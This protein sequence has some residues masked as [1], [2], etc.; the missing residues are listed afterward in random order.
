MEVL[1]NFLLDLVKCE[2][3][4]VSNE[5]EDADIE[6]YPP[7]FSSSQNSSGQSL[8]EALDRA[9]RNEMKMMQDS[10][11]A[12]S[13]DKKRWPVHILEK[14][15]TS[16][17][18]QALSLL[19]NKRKRDVAVRLLGWNLSHLEYANATDAWKLSKKH[20]DEDDAGYLFS[21]VEVGGLHCS[22]TKGT[23]NLCQKLAH[24]LSLREH[25]TIQYNQQVQCVTQLSNNRVRIETN[26]GHIIDA[27]AVVVTLPLGV[28]KKGSVKF[29]PSLPEYKQSVIDRM[30]FGALNKVMLKFPEP[31]F[32][33]D[34]PHEYIG[35]ASSPRNR[36]YNFFIVHNRPVLVG[37]VSGDFAR[38]IETANPK[39]VMA[40]CMKIIRVAF[41]HHDVPDPVDIHIT[42]WCSD[43]YALG[44]YSYM[45]VNAEAFD[46]AALAQPV[47]RVFFAGE[48][49]NSK[50]PSSMHGAYLSGVREGKRICIQNNKIDSKAVADHFDE[51]DLSVRSNKDTVC[52]LCRQS[53][54]EDDLE[55]AFIGG[56]G[57]KRKVF[58]HY[59]CALFTPE[60]KQESVGWFNVLTAIR[61]GKRHKC[62]VCS[63]R[64]ATITCN[65]PKCNRTY[66]FRCAAEATLPND[67][68]R[69]AWDFRTNGKFYFC[70]YH[71]NTKTILEAHAKNTELIHDDKNP[72]FPSFTMTRARQLI[73]LDFV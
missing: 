22:L 37:I 69:K 49:T 39:D 13:G 43:P 21:G 34:Y 53:H 12:K 28:L 18:R 67:S 51:I 2:E 66:H 54:R 10:I 64:G 58:V 62:S 20:W 59:Y 70:P 26:Q 30:G 47:G 29:E 41:P 57:D 7:I 1:W 4:N 35:H 73:Q 31:F 55:G 68:N 6:K 44:S 16:Q 42:K 33:A 19:Q 23:M 15:N 5:I 50:N 45:P 52:A 61:R 32:L 36:F 8:A 24:E 65:A 60:V 48:A 71:V 56:F 14:R 27:D 3:E 63:K 9:L 72:V 40:H 25:V 17:I 38:Q 11:S 46:M